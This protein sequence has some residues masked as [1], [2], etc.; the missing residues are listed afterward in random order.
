MVEIIGLVTIEVETSRR[1]QVIT[2]LSLAKAG[3]ILTQ[4]KNLPNIDEQLAFL[5][6]HADA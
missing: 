4:A 6:E 3:K 2:F 1:T 5:K